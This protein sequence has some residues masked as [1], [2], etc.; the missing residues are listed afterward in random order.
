MKASLELFPQAL[1]VT[2]EG[3]RRSCLVKETSAEGEC[4]EKELWILYPVDVPMPE[5]DDCD[6]YLLATFL[7]AM[8]LQADITVH[9]SA[10]AQLLA[11]LTEL[12]YVWSKWCPELY[13]LVEIK[14][15]RIRKNDLRVAG[16]IVAFSGGADAQFT[17][18]RHTRSKA[19]YATQKLRGGVLVHGFDIPLVDQAGFLGAQRMAADALAGLELRLFSVKTNLAVLGDVNWEHRC[20][21]GVAAILTGFRMYAET[22]FIGSSEP[23]DALLVPWGTHPLI[24]PL[25]SSGSFR[26]IHDGAGFSR[27]EKIKLLCEWQVNIK[28]LRVCWAGGSND[29]N[30][31]LCEKCVRTR[32]NFLL[33]G[34]AEPAC[35]ST[36]FEKES[37]KSIVLMSEA[38]RAEWQLIRNEIV[39]TGV[40]V[41]WLPYVEKVLKR[42][43]SPRL[44]FLF[45][46]GSKRRALVKKMLE[47]F[48]K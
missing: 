48:R 3:Q 10:C 26:I 18:Y 38:A 36:K 37:L 23:Y 6:S 4:T 24:D 1:Q 8:K 30:C 25:S 2:D 20:G 31:G 32:F 16:A 40:G 42:K 9:G 5:D 22:G 14:V 12:Q 34:V 27:S 29:R 35:F 44:G 28:N 46:P 47:S 39:K 19:G 43:S 45:P 15:E 33:A 17:A 13:F 21:I 41:E 7:T 11:N